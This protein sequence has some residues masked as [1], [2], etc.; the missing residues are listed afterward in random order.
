MTQPPRL[1]SRQAARRKVALASKAGMVSVLSVTIP[2]LGAPW[3]AT[4]L[5]GLCAVL[6]LQLVGLEWRLLRRSAPLLPVLD[7]LAPHSANLS[8]GDGRAFEHI[9][10]DTAVICLAGHRASTQAFLQV[11]EEEISSFLDRVSGEHVR[12]VSNQIVISGPV[13]FQYPVVDSTDDADPLRSR[14]LSLAQRWTM[15]RMSAKTGVMVP[16]T[17]DMQALLDHVE[18]SDFVKDIKLSS[19]EGDD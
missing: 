17:D 18:R 11:P 5:C 13:V 14:S 3:W 12:L 4:L 19:S 2:L 16:S 7:A 1:P 10:G 9:G 6:S 15:V 8:S